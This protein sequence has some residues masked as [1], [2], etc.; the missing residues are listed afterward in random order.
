MFYNDTFRVFNFC[1]TM[2]YIT[3]ALRYYQPEP[4]EEED[5]GATDAK[6]E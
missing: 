2:F 5:G 4:A 6:I 3:L 1:V